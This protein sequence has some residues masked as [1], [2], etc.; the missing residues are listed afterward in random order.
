MN[1]PSAGFR[2]LDH[3][4]VV[5]DPQNIFAS[6]D[7]DWASPFF[8]DA[9]ANI[10]RL[11]AAFGDRVLITRWLPTAD[12]DTS[13]GEYFADWPFADRPPSDPLFDLVPAVRD[14][15]TRPTLDRPTFGKWGPDMEA[16]VGRGTRVVLT[17]VSTDC[18][19]LST[20]LTAADA[21][22]YA[23]IAADACA[24]STAENHAAA[25]H[26]M[27]LYPPQLTLSD[28]ASILAGDQPG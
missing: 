14:L 3:W 13:W 17:G 5:I 7:S 24:G 22:A 26:V 19:V 10:K 12:R 23:I 25:L 21:G 11:A 28:T 1:T 2:G 15:S 8:D 4:L 27:G 9:V 16:I 20:A 18:C 6:P